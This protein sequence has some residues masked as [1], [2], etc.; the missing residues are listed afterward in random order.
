VAIYAG[1]GHRL[2]QEVLD[3]KIDAFITTGVHYQDYLE[4]SGR[5]LLLDIGYHATQLGLKK[6]IVAIL[7]K[8]FNNIVILRCKTTTNPIHY[9]NN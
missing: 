1:I 5:M 9:I 4:A 6:V 7:S 3:A 2:L 8:E